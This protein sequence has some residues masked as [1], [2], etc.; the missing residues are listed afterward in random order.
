[1]QITRMLSLKILRYLLDNPNF[2]FPFKIICKDFYE[3]DELY[4]I[5]VF[6]DYY[7]EILENESLITFVLEE[8]IQHLYLQTVELMS[9]GFIEKI[10]NENLKKKIATLAEEYR[11]NWKEDLWESCDIEEF[12]L[13]EYIGGK[14]D[15]YE[16]CLRILKENV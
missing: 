6:E 1:M 7:N 2:Y 5:E 4:E 14:A 3:D 13:N 9:K 10:L 8:N 16:D 15:A 12:G 11:E